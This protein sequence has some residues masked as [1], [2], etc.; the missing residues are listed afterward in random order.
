MNI[1]HYRTWGVYCT[2]DST[3]RGPP[4]SSKE[5]ANT[6]YTVPN[7]TMSSDAS[8]RPEAMSRGP[9]KSRQLAGRTSLGLD[10]STSSACPAL[11]PWSSSQSP[12]QR[13]LMISTILCPQSGATQAASIKQVTVK[14]A[15]SYSARRACWHVTSNRSRIAGAWSGC[16]LVELAAT[17]AA[18][19]LLVHAIKRTS[20]KKQQANGPQFFLKEKETRARKG[21]SA[22]GRAPICLM[23]SR[24]QTMKNAVACIVRVQAI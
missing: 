13:G 1:I 22:L 14:W 9:H 10:P 19:R 8:P 4:D 15:H 17:A 3:G 18:C 6:P 7:H 12:T 21:A 5:R 23:Q 20:T 24:R 11:L 16:A 2:A